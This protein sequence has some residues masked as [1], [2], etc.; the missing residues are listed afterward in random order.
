MNM[1]YQLMYFGW[2]LNILM[3]KGK[4]H[5][6]SSIAVSGVGSSPALATCETRQVLL[7]RWFSWGTTVSHHLSI[8][9]SL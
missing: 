8:G 9:S 6:V 1:T 5:F 3:G 2:I 7:V 4:G